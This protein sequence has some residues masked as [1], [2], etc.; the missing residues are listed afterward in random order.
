M[1]GKETSRPGL[2]RSLCAR[3]ITTRQAAEAL[4]LS[5]RQVRRLKARFQADGARGLVHRGRG[6]PSPRPSAR[7]SARPSYTTTRDT[8]AAVATSRTSSAASGPVSPAGSRRLPDLRVHGRPRRGSLRAPIRAGL[9]PGHR[10]RMEV[11]E[12]DRS[13]GASVKAKLTVTLETRESFS[14]R[15][16]G[17]FRPARR[18][19]DRYKA[20]AGGTMPV[21]PSGPPRRARSSGPEEGRRV[22]TVATPR[23]RSH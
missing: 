11:R 14:T 8:I 19:G 9:V 1:S 6:Q 7:R 23:A 21:R 2:L 18:N 5:P 20:L 15:W 10:L 17:R 16:R 4:R 12:G 3:L 13:A 22:V